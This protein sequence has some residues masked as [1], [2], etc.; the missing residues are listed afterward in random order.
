MRN[1]SAV[2]V[3]TVAVAP[4]VLFA[5]LDPVICGTH[6]ENAKE[7]LFLH[8]QAVRHLPPGRIRPLAA[9][10]ES[11]RD[12]G[13]IAL[14]D[15]SNGVVVRR[16]PFDLN[17]KTLRF[18]PVQS[19]ATSY[20]FEVADGSYDAAAAASGTFLKLGDDD[21]QAVA[22]PFAFPYFGKSYQQLFV[23][24]DGNVTFTAGDAASTDR[25]F[26]RFIGGVPRIAALFTDLDPTQAPTR[27]G[28]LVSLEARRVVVSWTGVPLYSQFGN[29]RQQ[30][31][32]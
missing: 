26:G 4:L 32:Q 20:Q 12:A 16:N 19:T 22:L 24:S 6:G 30:T 7:E 9:P 15:D 17:Q 23:N 10:K 3:L 28:I 1:R 29:G 18:L 5:R 13:Q 8:R 11:S 27:R 25:S 2:C 14:I 21:S 31:F